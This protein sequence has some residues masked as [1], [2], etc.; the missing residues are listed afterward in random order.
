MGWEGAGFLSG[1]QLTVQVH[2]CA[3]CGLQNGFT[4]LHI[5]CK[6]NHI[7]VMELLLKTGA[8]IDAV[9]EVGGSVGMPSP[10][11]HCLTWLF[12]I[13][14]CACRY[15]C[16]RECVHVQ[17]YVSMSPKGLGQGDSQVRGLSRMGEDGLKCKVV[18]IFYQGFCPCGHF[19]EKKPTWFKS[20]FS[21][22]RSW[23]S[24]STEERR[25]LRLAL[26]CGDGSC[27]H[28]TLSL[29]VWT[30]TSP[31]GVLHGTPSYCEELTAAG[32]VTQC[33]QCGKI[34]KTVRTLGAGPQL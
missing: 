9:T 12:L 29:L 16:A 28:S 13:A 22:S 1:S 32:G 6:K 4:P 33:L 24:L 15:A 14:V 26:P 10:R 20:I 25:I 11:P 18:T 19:P 31:R 5:A 2:P 34:L 21:G 23:S 7:R 30:D 3:L 27:S 17:V 8:S